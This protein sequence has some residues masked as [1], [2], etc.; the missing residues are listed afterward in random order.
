MSKQNQKTFIF[1]FYFA[2]FAHSRRWV[3]KQ[4]AY[5]T[6]FPIMLFALQRDVAE[7]KII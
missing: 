6:G 5:T 4:L 1:F 3:L 7:K 2:P